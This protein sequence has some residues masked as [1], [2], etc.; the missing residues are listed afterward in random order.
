MKRHFIYYK[1]F[2]VPCFG[3]YG[4][5]R[6]KAEA[7]K[8]A[9]NTTGFEKFLSEKEYCEMYDKMLNVK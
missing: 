6:T 7:Q 4:D 1:V 2:N 9:Q 5:G 3:W 8:E